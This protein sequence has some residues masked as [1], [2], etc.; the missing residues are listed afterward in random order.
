MRR[1]GRVNGILAVCVVASLTLAACTSKSK[2]SPSASASSASTSASGAPSSGAASAS[3]SAP[4]SSAPAA[5][6]GD[7]NLNNTGTPVKGGTLHLLGVGDV[8][9]MDPNISYYSGGYMGLRLWSRQ[10]VTFPAIPGKTTTDAP[11]LA[12]QLPTTANGGISADGLTYKFTIRK[13]VMWNTT[14]ARQV[15]AAD[16]VRGVKRT[17]NPAQPFGGEPDFQTLIGGLDAFCT[18]FAKVDP[19]SATA[20]AAYQNNTPLSGVAVDSADPNTVVFTL[21]RPASYFIAMLSLT[22]FSPSP[23]EYDQYIPAGAD[24]A[25]HTISDGPYEVTSYTATKEIDFARNP[26]WDASTDPIRKAYVDKVVVNETGD[27]TAIQAQLQANTAGADMEWDTFPPV[28]QVTQL[29]AAKDPNFYLGPTFSTN[30]YVI[31]NTV[32]PNNSGALTKVAVRKALEEAISRDNLIQDMNG[33]DVS[34]PLTHVLPAGISGTTSNNS[35]DIYKY[36]ATKAKADLAAAGA[37]GLTLKIL[38]RPKS[39]SS[40]KIYTTLQ[41]DLGLAGIKVT[42]VGVPN[43]DFYTKYLQVP[44]VAKAGTWDVSIAGWGPDWYGNA[45]LSFFGPLF[46]GANGAAFPPNGSDFGLYD[47]PATDALI[48]QASKEQDESKANALWVKADQ[49]VMDDAAFFPITAP[50]QPTYHAS[51]THN[52]IFIPTLQQID[53]SNVW[54]SGS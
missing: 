19:K 53:P 33:P 2:S 30:P 12:T 23:V 40:S 7:E 4:V 52:T 42:G 27:Q 8:D 6:V 37:A 3:A 9:Y 34:P 22:A 49:Q 16:M 44:T 39:S 20:I 11:D 21:T 1:V 15:T 32:S 54:L 5:A 14:P 50:L 26:A 18:G 10:L 31:F 46:N 13:G 41:Q 35:I 36:D 51:H 17:C 47:N 29:K 45:A 38:Y 48:D 28:S 25:A 24:L 43:A